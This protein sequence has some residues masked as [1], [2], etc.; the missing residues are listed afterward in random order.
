MNAGS[1]II[2]KLP[3]RTVKI[4]LK[5]SLSCNIIGHALK[6]QQSAALMVKVP[7]HTF[8]SEV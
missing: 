6:G 3:Q 4:K 7:K 1:D 8:L 2:I 5:K